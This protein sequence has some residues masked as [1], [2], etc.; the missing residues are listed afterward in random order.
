MTEATT[1][2]SDTPPRP[3]GD[4][5]L[6]RRRAQVRTL[7]LRGYSLRQMTV[8]L[9]AAKDFGHMTKSS[10]QRDVKAVRVELREES[11]VDAADLYAD[12]T[13]RLDGIER[14]LWQTYLGIE[15]ELPADVDDDTVTPI[16]KAIHRRH[17]AGLKA[18]LLA[19]LLTVPER[20]VKVGQALGFVAQAPVQVEVVQKMTRDL[21]DVLMTDP[22]AEAVVRRLTRR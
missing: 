12:A 13:A 18:N 8:V 20:R 11:T 1:E 2:P 19:Y 7:L 9:N 16:D 6:D 4:V 15:D 17:A 5:A 10:V 14:E 22:E 21:A 3:R